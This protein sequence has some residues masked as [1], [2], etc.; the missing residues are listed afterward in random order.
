MAISLRNKQLEEL[1]RQLA[2]ERGKS[3]TDVIIEALETRAGQ[4]GPVS[5]LER[6]LSRIENAAHRIASLP[7]LSTQKPDEIIGYDQDGL[8]T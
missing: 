8:P 5:R 6:D 7:V 2:Y 3:L 4:L 1:A